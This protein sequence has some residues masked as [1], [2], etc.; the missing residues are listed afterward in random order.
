MSQVNTVFVDGDIGSQVEELAGYIAKLKG[1]TESSLA[2]TQDYSALCDESIALLQAVSDKEIEGC[3][4]LLITLL[5]Q[6]PSDQLPSLLSRVLSSLVSDD[7]V[8]KTVIKMRIL[9]NLYNTL[10]AT[11]KLRYDVFEALL[12]IA[13]KGEELDVLIP[14][15]GQLEEGL[16]SWGVGVDK[17]RE[18][19][20]SVSQKLQDTDSKLS[21]Q[22]LIK[23]LATFDDDASASPD[24]ATQL[25]IKAT[26]Q[27]IRQPD[28]LAFDDLL[29][30]RAITKLSGQPLYALLKIF[31]NGNLGDYKAWK[32]QNAG[33]L[34]KH[35]LS[36][37]D[38]VRK[39]R[40]LS[41]ASLGSENLANEIK[42][43]RI[44][45]AL[46]ISEDEVEMWVIDVIRAGLI[47]A[48][49][50][51]VAKT[52]VINRSMFRAFGKEQWQLLS[53]RLDGWRRSLSD[54]L[55]VI[56]NAKLIAQQNVVMDV[57]VN[58]DAQ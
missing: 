47:E 39:M 30:L 31:A 29:R 46:E 9:S 44:A 49:L 21:L 17:R 58:G 4:N 8:D 12:E 16:R 13:A 43:D 41:L 53:S 40:L 42:Y 52:V 6:L 45:Q 26:E 48:K 22:F 10:D 32:Q 23:A 27:A 1:E 14:E 33:I 24:A 57:A 36:D 38:N 7:R 25:A 2:S 5:M 11:S 20:L 56:G 55:Q 28:I 3:Y 50:N 35:N 51:Q 37:E 19:F 15:L 54:V 34:E 18:M